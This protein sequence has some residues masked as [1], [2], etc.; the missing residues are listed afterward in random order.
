MIKQRITI[1]TTI[2]CKCGADSLE[3]EVGGQGLDAELPCRSPDAALRMAIHSARGHGLT[4][5]TANPGHRLPLLEA[6]V[7]C[8]RCAPA[9][10]EPL[11]G[12][13]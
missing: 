7:F 2:A 10:D 1:K 12:G 6:K 9:S 8:S 13:E 4:V 11:A 5:T 3:L